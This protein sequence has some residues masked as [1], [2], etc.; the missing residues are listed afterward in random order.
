MGFFSLHWSLP[1]QKTPPGSFILFSF[2]P[3][4]FIFKVLA[5][6]TPKQ[7]QTTILYLSSYVPLGIFKLTSLYPDFQNIPNFFGNTCI[8]G[9]MH[10]SKAF[11]KSGRK[12]WKNHGNI[13]KDL[14]PVADI[15]GDILL[16]SYWK[17]L[18][19]QLHPWNNEASDLFV[20]FLVCLF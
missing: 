13:F 17:S 2:I 1:S 3:F 10:N 6:E 11:G 18:F 8:N 20:P 5:R 16:S 15:L 19:G 12:P 7:I 4:T 14:T 9:Q